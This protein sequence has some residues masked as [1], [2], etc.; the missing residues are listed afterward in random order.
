MGWMQHRREEKGGWKKIS[1]HHLLCAVLLPVVAAPDRLG[2]MIFRVKAGGKE[3]RRQLV[4]PC[5]AT[6]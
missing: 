2:W 3:T 6:C 4:L 1:V 5:L